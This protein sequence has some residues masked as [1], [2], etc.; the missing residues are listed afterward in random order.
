MPEAPPTFDL[1]DKIQQ[2]HAPWTIPD[3]PKQLPIAFPFDKVAGAKKTYNKAKEL[4]ICTK[5]CGRLS[6][7]GK[8][9]CQECAD[10]A[11]K[12]E[13]IRNSKIMGKIAAR[14][15]EWRS[16]DNGKASRAG[17]WNRFKAQA[18][19]YTRYIM[20]RKEKLR[21][22]RRECLQLYGGK[23]VCC[24]E[25]TFEFLSF[26]HKHGGGYAERRRLGGGNGRFYKSLKEEYRTD[27]QILCHNCNQARGFYGICPHEINA[28]GEVSNGAGI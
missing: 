5:W 2:E 25:T 12:R 15:K 7:P 28:H 13:K 22:T 1:I 23:C 9:K 10:T 26:D 4:G 17:E 21:A 11:S 8:T 16:T 14:N 27:I 24:G 20:A 3:L 18:N 6:R 19:R